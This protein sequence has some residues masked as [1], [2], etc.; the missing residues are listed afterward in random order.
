[1]CVLGS[2]DVEVEGGTEDARAAT[3]WEAVVP[4]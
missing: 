2:M 4:L 1:M 3:V